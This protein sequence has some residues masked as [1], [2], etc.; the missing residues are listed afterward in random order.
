MNKENF[1]MKNYKIII[2]IV[3][4]INYTFLALIGSGIFDNVASSFFEIYFILS[5]TLIPIAAIFALLYT[6]HK[7]AEDINLKDYSIY[8]PF[9]QGALFI[10]LF[11]IKYT[12]QLDRNFLWMFVVMA[13]TFLG[14]EGVLVSFIKV[15]MSKKSYYVVNSFSYLTM[16]AYILLMIVMAYDYSVLL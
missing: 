2:S 3:M 1:Y 6:R 13:L 7:K 5:F 11:G 10:L 14:V 16:L 8:L 15:D 12:I 9:I 4:F